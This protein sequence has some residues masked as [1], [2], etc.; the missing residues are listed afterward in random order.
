MKRAT[1]GNLLVMHGIG[2][3]DFGTG[4]YCESALSF[5]RLRPSLVG[6]GPHYQLNYFSHLL[7]VK[8][9]RHVNT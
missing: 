4:V 9:L 2:T 8:S 5:D 7:I 1:L 3:E 6:F